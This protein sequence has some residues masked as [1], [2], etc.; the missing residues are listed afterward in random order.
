MPALKGWVRQVR[1]AVVG[2]VR[3]RAIA[4]RFAQPRTSDDC[5]IGARNAERPRRFSLFSRTP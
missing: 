1:G 5:R 2:R 3:T 4:H